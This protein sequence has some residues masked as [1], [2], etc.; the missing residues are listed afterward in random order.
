MRHRR[1]H[2]SLARLGTELPADFPRMQNG[3]PY[4][5]GV[6]Y[7]VLTAIEGSKTRGFP[8]VYVFRCREPPSVILTDAGWSETETEWQRL[9]TFFETW[10]PSSGYFKYAFQTFSSAD[11]FEVLIE[12]TLV[13]W[14]YT[15][16]FRSNARLVAGAIDQS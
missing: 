11:E 7:E 13:E 12:R 10:F 1:R 3:E 6:A 9:E 5:S 4:P 8:D 16:G 15:N 14:L 2:F